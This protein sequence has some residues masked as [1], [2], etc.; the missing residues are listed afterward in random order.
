[1]FLLGIIAIL[2]GILSLLDG[3]RSAKHIKTFRPRKNTTD[4]VL[5]FCPC[6]GIDAEFEK[7]VRSILEQDYPNYDVRFVVESEH[8]PAFAVL[9][10]IGV[11]DIVIAGPAKDRGQK[12]HNLISAV[13][14]APHDASIFV[15]CDSDARFPRHWLSSLVAPLKHGNVATGYRW[16]VADS[17]QLPTLFHS[18]W[19]ASIVT[20]LGDHQHNFAWGGSMALRRSTFEELRILD[21]WAGALSDDFAVTNTAEKSAAPIVFVPECLVPSYGRC[22][23]RELLEFTTRQIIITRVYNPRMWRLAFVSQ[24]IFNVAFWPL[25]VR[26]SL[27]AAVIYLLSVGKNWVR[28]D[29]VRSVLPSAVLSNSR[30]FYILSSPFIGL[31]YLYNLLRSAFTREIVWRQIHYKL[32]SPSQTDVLRGN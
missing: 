19:N 1:M 11:S 17:F 28:L 21:A 18:A 6:K 10:E 25:L 9:R 22:S 4:R 23:W 29:A 8:D 24:L 16:Y 32:I 31:L 15:F 30:W 3:F 5:V 13:Q 2:Q 12:V 20:Q 7:N 27:L 14:T 26:G